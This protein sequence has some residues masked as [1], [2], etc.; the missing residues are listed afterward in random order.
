MKIKPSQIPT[1]EPEAMEYNFL[2]FG[3]QYYVAARSAVL[4][5]LLPVSGNLYHHAIEMFLKAGL[6]SNHSTVKF[7]HNLKILWKE[8]KTEFE[9][10]SFEKYDSTITS[11]DA[12]ESIR[13]P[14]KLIKEGARMMTVW[15]TVDNSM[16]ISSNMQP[17]M[18]KVVVNDIDE[19][20]INIFEICSK[21]PKFFVV[22]LSDYGRNVIVKDNPFSI[23]WFNS[24]QS[25]PHKKVLL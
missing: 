2:K 16:A 8:F 7:G 1:H 14:N 3:V 4:A 24:N 15:N 20:I 25:L 12:F 11:L 23:K 19:L 17:P 22:T 10:S 21:N 6:S 13:Y 5:G 9:K 18:Y